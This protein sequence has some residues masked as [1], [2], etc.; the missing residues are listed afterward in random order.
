MPIRP[1]R[2][3]SSSPTPRTPTWRSAS[4][5]RA[6]RPRIMRA[7]CGC[8]RWPSTASRFARSSRQGIVDIMLMSASTNDMLDIQRA[9]VRKQ[10]RHA[11]RAGQRHQRHVRRA[12]RA[13]ICRAV[14]AVPHGHARSHPMRPRRLRAGRA[15]PRRRPGPVQHHVQQP[16]RRRPAALEEYRHFRIEAEAKGFR[17]FLEVFDPNAPRGLVEPTDLPKFI[18]DSIVR[19]L[20]GVAQAGRP[21]FLKVVYHG[22]GRWK[23]WSTYDPHLVVGILGGGCR[24]DL[25]RLQADRRSAEYGARV[26][27]SAARST[28]PRCQLAFVEFL[29]LIVDGVISPEEAV[30][31]YHGVLER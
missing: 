12:R 18:N 24:H 31:A 21:V 2:R 15:S 22:P 28:T 7:K 5:R 25:R 26:A 14:A 11:R 6:S 13:R 20:A 17:H 29:R 23:N 8:A 10:P 4:A 3:S 9:A 1:A 16:A 27:C 19:T 30:R